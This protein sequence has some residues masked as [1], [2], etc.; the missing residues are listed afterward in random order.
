MKLNIY[1]KII[2]IMDKY[3]NILNNKKEINNNECNDNFFKFIFKN[4]KI[5][6]FENNESN[7]INESNNDYNKILIESQNILNNKLVLFNNK[8]ESKNIFNKTEYNNEIKDF[9]KKIYKRIILKS[10]P[11]KN[12]NKEN[13]IKCQK[14][15]QDNFLI[16]LL[17]L[18]YKI[19]IIDKTIDEII[20]PYQLTD[21]VIKTIF[22]EIRIIQEK[23]NN[24]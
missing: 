10:H 14:Y 20:F 8:T 16:G 17:Y 15:Y 22:V 7:E 12:G 5:E 1:Q 2:E 3:E 4:I 9:I 11:D 18:F 19:E 21:L 24:L 23:I 6:K 13:F